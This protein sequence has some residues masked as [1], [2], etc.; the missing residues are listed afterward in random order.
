MKF[1][2]ILTLAL[3]SVVTF[4][5]FAS[6]A[7][8]MG[9]RNGTYTCD[10]G[11]AYFF[12]LAPISEQTLLSKGNSAIIVQR[13]GNLRNPTK[14]LASLTLEG[15]IKPNGDC[16]FKGET[17]SLA[18]DY[19]AGTATGLFEGEL[20]PITLKCHLDVGGH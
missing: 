20:F 5:S 9:F 15:S 17:A 4:G 13:T 12:Q 2:G 18:L 1:T 16:Q 8:D 6:S 11:G 3:S 19:R 10:E 7:N 14:V